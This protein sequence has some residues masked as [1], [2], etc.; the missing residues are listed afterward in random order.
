MALNTRSGTGSV[1]KGHLP[2][3]HVEPE[4]V[5]T[6]ESVKD[7]PIEDAQDTQGR[8]AQDTESALSLH[9]FIKKSVFEKDNGNDIET[10]AEPKTLVED[11]PPT[12]PMVAPPVTVAPIPV[13]NA[14]VPSGLTKINAL[15][16]QYKK[17]KAEKAL[18][19]LE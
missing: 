6:L 2:Y 15:N 17:L 7:N 12:Q 16:A 19:Q 13:I 5:L 10:G 3:G 11:W 18:A 14:W 1:P 4:K 9:D 8:K